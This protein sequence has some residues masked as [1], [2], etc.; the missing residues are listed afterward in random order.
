MKSLVAPFPWQP[1]DRICQR[2]LGRLL[3][4]ACLLCGRACDHA[5]L[6]PGCRD[7]IPGHSQPHCPRC[8]LRL[9]HAD[10]PHPCLEAD[11]P[12]HRVLS[13]ADYAAPLDRALNALKFDQQTALARPLAELLLQGLHDSRT[14]GLHTVD[15][16][17]PIPLSGQRLAERGF[18]Q[19][20][21]IAR[22]LI[23][24]AAGAAPP[25]RHGWLQRI[26]HTRPQSSLDAAARRQNLR[27]AF[28]ASASVAQLRIAL[29]DDVM[30]TGSTLLEAARTL[31]AAGAAEVVAWVVART[32]APGSRC[33]D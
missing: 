8:A 9:R 12:L 5:T 7:A 28:L 24:A 17:I 29:V 25:L 22:A 13:G 19:S 11:S 18:N 33:G 10:E 14:D 27:N 2:V 3:P 16:I 32:P 23:R 1:L 20:L 30:T 21:L 15:A 6:C 4:R 26:R 31:K